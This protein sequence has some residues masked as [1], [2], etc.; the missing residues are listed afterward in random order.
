VSPDHAVASVANRHLV[1]NWVAT[2][3]M[4]EL[5]SMWIADGTAWE[6]VR[7]QRR[8]LRT[9][10]QIVHEC[11]R[12]VEFRSHP[13]SLHIWLRLPPPWNEDEFVAHAR[14]RG[15]A[16]AP[17]AS[18]VTTP[19]YTAGG[20]RICIGAGEAGELRRGLEIIT[21]ILSGAPKPAL[22]TI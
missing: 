21:R 19:S 14:L 16:V 22:L 9:R 1:T 2:P 20:V 12:G 3:I 17:G 13:E 10:Y 18:F 6:L 7:W 8:A 15:V 11:L 5:A 4:S